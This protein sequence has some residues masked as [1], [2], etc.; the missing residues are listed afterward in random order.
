MN[1]TYEVN[2]LWRYPVKSLAG[3]AVESVELDTGG[4]AGDRRWGFRDLDTGRLA[5]AK[6]PRPFGGLLDWSARITHDGTVEV[7]APGATRPRWR[8]EALE[9]DDQ[10]TV[11]LGL[12][13]MHGSHMILPVATETASSTEPPSEY[14]DCSASSALRGQPC[15][16]AE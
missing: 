4:V 6:K 11:E 8:W 2:G 14:P 15:R 9:Y 10:V 3:E 12:G 13:G 1:D 7:A 16:M 5:S